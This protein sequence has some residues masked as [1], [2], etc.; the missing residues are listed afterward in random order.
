[1]TFTSWLLTFQDA[2]QAARAAYDRANELA[3]ELAKVRED[4]EWHTDGSH[5]DADAL[6]LM[7]L[8]DDEVYPGYFDGAIWRYADGMP[9]SS[10]EVLAWRQFPAPR[11]IQI[12]SIPA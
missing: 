6:V 1:M 7:H 5:P 8:A 12:Q 11:P 10:H 4:T 2:R 3:A 9:V